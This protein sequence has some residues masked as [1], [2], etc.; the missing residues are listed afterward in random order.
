MEDFIPTCQKVKN[1]ENHH[2]SVSINRAIDQFAD[3]ENYHDFT[4][5][6]IVSLETG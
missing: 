1:T 6:K 2:D 5:T 3:V 4:P